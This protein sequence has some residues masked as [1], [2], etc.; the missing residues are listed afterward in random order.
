MFRIAT[1]KTLTQSCD[2]QADEIDAATGAPRKKRLR[3]G[4]QQRA[5]AQD[6]PFLSDDDRAIVVPL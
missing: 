6:A 5:M 4:D 1:I 2:S 3:I